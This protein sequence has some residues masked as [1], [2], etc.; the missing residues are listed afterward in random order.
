[1]PN[2]R[3]VLFASTH[4]AQRNCPPRPDPRE[5]GGYVWPVH[6]EFDIFVANPVDG[7]A[8]RQLTDTDGYDAEATVS[9]KGDRIVFTSSRD[10]DLDL[11]SMN[12]DGG[13][14]QRLT[15]KTGY[16]G[17][18]FYSWDG[19]RIVYRGHHPKTKKG[20]ETFRS[21]LARGVVRPSKM[22]IFVMDADGRN[23]R[24]IT[25]FGAASFAPF[26]HP[27]NK[28]IVFVSN[29]QDPAGRNFE[30]YMMRADGTGI[31]RITFN[32]TFDGFPMFDATGTK[33]VF[34]SNRANNQLGETNIFIAEWSD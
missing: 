31:E 19:K 16:D 24:Q 17:G 2:N 26:F 9:P 1:M 20:I 13:D 12:I 14:V 27:D 8:L 22:E 33:L 6:A 29:F 10:G 11:Y 4:I 15:N 25:S 3:D 7:G 23:K 18:A 34:A 32:P 28:R 30:I 21:L 5:F